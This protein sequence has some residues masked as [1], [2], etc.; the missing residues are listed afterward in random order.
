MK[1]LKGLLSLIILV[2]LLTSMLSACGNKFNSSN[3]TYSDVLEICCDAINE[4]DKSIISDFIYED[5][6]DDWNA[7][8]IFDSIDDFDEEYLPLENSVSGYEMY[9]SNE[10][11]KELQDWIFEE[12]NKVIDI[13]KG[14]EIGMDN[15]SSMEIFLVMIQEKW[16][17]L[18]FD[19]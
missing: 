13:D 17:I 7:N 1:K 16:Y 2:F 10:D 4:K 3:L 12:T 9:D 5:F 8:M 15:D 14:M 6:G 18:Y 19:L 11:L